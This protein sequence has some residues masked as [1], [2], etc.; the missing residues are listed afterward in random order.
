[1]VEIFEIDYGTS[2]KLSR[3]SWVTNGE[4]VKLDLPKT[5]EM[6]N[7]PPIASHK[8]GNVKGTCHFSL[9]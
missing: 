8:R 5:S 6:I 7:M 3:G 4:E 2:W 1:M 9:I